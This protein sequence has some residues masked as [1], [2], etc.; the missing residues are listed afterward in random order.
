MDFLLKYQHRIQRLLSK[1]FVSLGLPTVPKTIV[2]DARNGS[3]VESYMYTSLVDI[4]ERTPS[5]EVIIWA[6]QS[7]D[8]S[9]LTPFVRFAH[10]LDC[11]V[12]IRSYDCLLDIPSTLISM[13]VLCVTQWSEKQDVVLSFPLSNMSI[14]VEYNHETSTYLDAI[15]TRFDTVR[16]QKI[17][18]PEFADELPKD[19]VELE[20]WLHKSPHQE[21]LL[22]INFR[23]ELQQLRATS[24][25]DKPG[26]ASSQQ[27]NIDQLHIYLD[28]EYKACP[29]KN[30]GSGHKKSIRECTQQCTSMMLRMPVIQ[31]TFDWSNRMQR[32]LK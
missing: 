12:T 27:C 1:G 8:V 21:A 22:Y 32:R 11:A 17:V 24:V 5:C 3:S 18:L 6:D 19:D 13:V 23:K 10:R 25:G 2:V 15:L 4:L 29:Y 7:T 9:L 26:F 16:E 20:R 31:E 28:R 14:E 30:P